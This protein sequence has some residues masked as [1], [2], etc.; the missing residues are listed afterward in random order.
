MGGEPCKSGCNLPNVCVD[1]NIHGE[2]VTYCGFHIC[3]LVHN[4]Q[5]IVVNCEGRL[6]FHILGKY[7]SFFQ[8]DGEPKVSECFRE[9]V[10]QALELL[11]SMCYDC[12]I[13]SKEH[14]P[15]EDLACFGSCSEVGQVEL[16]AIY[17]SD[18]DDFS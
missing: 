14:V 3:A 17:L 11:H 5:L 12:A 18:L 7:N 16:L 8:T 9:T 1:F 10:H 2:V 15:D 4:F 6:H 13:I